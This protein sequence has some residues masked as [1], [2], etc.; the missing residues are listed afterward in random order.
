MGSILRT[1]QGIKSVLYGRSESNN[2]MVK[3]FLSRGIEEP[4]AYTNPEELHSIIQVLK[5]RGYDSKEVLILKKFKG[6]F[7]QKCPGSP[8]VI[9]CN[10]HVINT[11]FNCLYACTYCYLNS[12]LNSYGIIQ[13][14]NITDIHEE[15]DR[16]MENERSDTIVRIGTGEFTDSL[17]MDESTGIGRVL[18]DRIG[19]KHNV[20][21]ELKTKSRNISHLLDVKEKGNS[22]LAWSLN[23]ERNIARYERGTAS[24]S[25][26]IEA[27]RRASEAGYFIAFHLDPIIAYSDWEREYRALIDTLFSRINPEKVVWISMGCFRYSPGFK[28]ILRERFPDEDLTAEE[29]FP[30][31][32]GKLRYLKRERI[33]IYKKI[34]ESIELYTDKP[35]LYMC[36]ESSDVW[37]S[38]FGK[39]YQHS[40][41]LESD[42]SSHLRDSFQ[43]I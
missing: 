16:F 5:K 31:I 34:R 40:K 18:I 21:L 13:F 8:G 27:A 14:T 43:I 7:F 6:R 42:L 22:V 26:R 12:Y 20:M 17:M 19:S 2:L 4:I 37:Y 32:D 28:E 41:E 24:L 10:Y 39:E 23:T 1:I 30:G 3:N 15:I 25:E 38:V 29:M 33:F 36:M 11:C 35:F 9:C